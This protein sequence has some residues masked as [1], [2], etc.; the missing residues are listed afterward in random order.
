MA[1]AEMKEAKTEAPKEE[2]VSYAPASPARTV[3]A[4]VFF[5]VE[6]RMAEALTSDEIRTKS[7]ELIAGVRAAL[8]SEPPDLVEAQVLTLQLRQ[9]NRLSNFRN[10]RLKERTAA[11]RH[12]TDLVF[13]KFHNFGNEIHHLKKRISEML[14]F[15]SRDED[16]ELIPVEEFYAHTA[17]K[18]VE[19]THEVKADEHRLRLARLEF[20]LKQREEM[21]EE[22]QQSDTK[23]NLLGSDI[24]GK[25]N[26]LAQIR[27]QIGLIRQAGKPLGEMLGIKKTE[28]P[29]ETS[30]RVR[31]FAA[32]LD[33]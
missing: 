18:G 30:E 2:D 22:L 28:M 9:L 3:N 25:E 8:R 5:A 11:A 27:A 21:S 20:E 7:S 31:Q 29:P 16:L 10:A 23:K 15:R 33:V 4:E 1:D 26:R 14:S 32:D 12:E 13:L 19:L 6:D 17:D 24:K